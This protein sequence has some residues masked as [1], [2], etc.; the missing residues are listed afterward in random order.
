M[1]GR[2]AFLKNFY[3]HCLSLVQKNS[4]GTARFMHSREG[5]TQGDPFDMVI[6]GIA[7]LPLTKRLKSDFVTST[8]SSMLMVSVH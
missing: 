7:V 3:H 2:S 1:S 4:N 6:Y 5:G 8:N